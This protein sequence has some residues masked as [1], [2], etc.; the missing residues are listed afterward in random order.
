MP[1]VQV[2]ANLS[3]DQLIKA[4]EQLSP[5]ELDEFVPRVMALRSRHSIASLPKAE[6][7][8]LLKVNEDLSPAVRQRYADLIAKRQSETLSDQ[9][10]DELLQLTR[11]VEAF[12]ARRVGYLAELARIRKVSLSE[13]INSLGIRE[14]NHA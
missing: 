9:E 11:Q 10:Y 7:D 6:A 3:V 2:E 14:P 8:L 5:P 12:Q 13:L 4:V 1:V